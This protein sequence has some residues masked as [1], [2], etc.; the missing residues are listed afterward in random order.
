MS[1][2]PTYHVAHMNYAILRHDWEDP[3]V[4]G[5]VDNLELV[6]AVAA[7]SP[8]FVWRLNIRDLRPFAEFLK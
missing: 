1:V 5:F 4:A 8:G 3:R 2:E 6:N 7:R